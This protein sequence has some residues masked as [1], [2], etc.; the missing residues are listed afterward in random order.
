M[1]EVTGEVDH[2]HRAVL[3]T[4]PGDNLRRLVPAAVVDEEQLIRLTGLI[5]HFLQA[6]VG[7]LYDRLFVKHRYDNRIFHHKSSSPPRLASAIKI[8][9]AKPAE[10]IPHITLINDHPG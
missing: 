1:A 10:G 8:P 7:L 3:L 2:P 6:L 9:G 5:H 4:E